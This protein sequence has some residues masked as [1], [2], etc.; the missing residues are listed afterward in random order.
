ML[1]QIVGPGTFAP[2]PLA[3]TAAER[4]AQGALPAE[5]ETAAAAT[6]P[7]TTDRVDP[8]RVVPAAMP[9]PEDRRRSETLLPPDPDAP[10]GPPPAFDATLLDRLREA[11]FAAPQPI[12][13]PPA[14]EPRA[15][16]PGDGPG[17][18][19]EAPPVPEDTTG[20]RRP[21]PDAGLRARA[22]A[23]VAEVRRM[24]APDP[25]RNLDV[26]R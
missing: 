24:S 20:A 9:L 26:V 22:E 16:S 12:A 17:D 13:S 4:S 3:P 23:E 19:A 21:D 25:A 1:P 6:R 8:P 11:D 10:A 5:G 14:A 7:E 18:D 2:A 15:A